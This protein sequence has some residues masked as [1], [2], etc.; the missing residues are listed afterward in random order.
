MDRATILDQA[1][2]LIAAN[3]LYTRG[4]YWPRASTDNGPDWAEGLPLDVAAAIGVAVGL[5]TKKDVSEQIAWL[6]M[7]DTD[8]PHPAFAALM[9]FSCATTAEQIFVWSDSARADQVIE[10]LRD[11]AASLRS[12]LAVA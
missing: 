8:E 1:A 6:D 11:C 5:R 7:D 12:S 2:D 4:D 3:K 9:E 10:R